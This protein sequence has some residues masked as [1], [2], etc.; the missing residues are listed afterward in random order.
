VFRKPNPASS[1]PIYTQIEEQIQH[2]IDT[3]ALV[4][5]DQ[6]PSIRA[7]AEELVI[8]A[9]TVI[10]V[11]RDL[12]AAGV[13][14]VRHG[15]GAFVAAS[16]RARRHT[17]RILSAQKLVRPV[18]EKLRALGLGDDEI[19]RLVEAEIMEPELRTRR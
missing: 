13:I 8:N 16:G 2:A 12:E 7:M 18:L 17:E 11:Y 3:G 4:S 15:L 1:V 14:E 10:R 19:R 9:N 5:G 6:L